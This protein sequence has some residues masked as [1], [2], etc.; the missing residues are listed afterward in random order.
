MFSNKEMKDTFSDCDGQACL[1]SYT[2]QTV[3]DKLVSIVTLASQWVQ[4]PERIEGHYNH[5]YVFP[6]SFDILKNFR[7]L[8]TEC[9]WVE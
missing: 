6:L 4:K 1:Y 3:T 2:G 7:Q 9:I 5:Y 8:I